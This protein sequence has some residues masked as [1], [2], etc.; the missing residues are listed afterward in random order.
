M[1]TCTSEKRS[2]KAAINL[3]ILPDQ[4]KN[5]SA[6][7]VAAAAGVAVSFFCIAIA[8]QAYISLATFIPIFRLLHYIWWNVR[9][10]SENTSPK[11]TYYN[12]T[13]KS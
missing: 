1:M 12:G 8:I 9:A 13:Y 7:I 6:F 11:H 10:S 5:A 4:Q 2:K 3:T